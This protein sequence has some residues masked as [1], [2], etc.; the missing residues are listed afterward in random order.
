MWISSL[1]NTNWIKVFL[2][3]NFIVYILGVLYAIVIYIVPWLPYS[4]KL[5]YPSAHMVALCVCTSAPSR[6]SV[7]SMTP[8]TTVL[9]LNGRHLSSF[10]SQRVRCLSRVIATDFLYTERALPRH[11]LLKMS[12]VALGGW[13]NT[14]LHWFSQYHLPW[15]C[16]H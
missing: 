11:R 16:K 7:C 6:F 2:H 8:L 3:I 4:S 15:V 10:C 9:V 5:I 12:I 14:Y 13:F 1:K